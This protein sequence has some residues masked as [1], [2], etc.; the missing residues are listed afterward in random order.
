VRGR[1]SSEVRIARKLRRAFEWRGEWLF[2]NRDRAGRGGNCREVNSMVKITTMPMK[3]TM[4]RFIVFF[5]F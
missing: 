2:W 4:V 5:P 3:S 1:W